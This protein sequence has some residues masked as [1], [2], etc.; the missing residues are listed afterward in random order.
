MKFLASTYS[1][2]PHHDRQIINKDAGQKIIVVS[3]YN[4]AN[5]NRLD[6][7]KTPENKLLLEYG[8]HLFS[9]IYLQQNK[10][11]SEFNLKGY[12]SILK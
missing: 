11:L 1:I 7:E 5:K 2:T 4:W 9:L 10:S 12:L 8:F 3:I 6:E